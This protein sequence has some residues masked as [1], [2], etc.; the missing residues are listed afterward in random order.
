MFLI[1]VEGLR[2]ASRAL[3]I[4]AVLLSACLL[5]SGCGTR[6]FPDTLD[7]DPG[8]ISEVRDIGRKMAQ[9]TKGYIYEN[10]AQNMDTFILDV[11]ASSFHE[12]LNIA[13]RRLRQRGWV[14]PGRV[15]EVLNDDAISM[16]SE[17]WGRTSV[18]IESL[19]SFEKYDIPWDP[20]TAKA[21]HANPVESATY[22]ALTVI[23]YA[24]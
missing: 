16:E 6:W 7:A 5:V 20:Q 2:R 17:K 18:R 12:A 23:P 10:T 22:V 13:H 3:R 11:E 4:A 15:D 8:A 24:F 21:L 19:K 14:L 9:T 1:R